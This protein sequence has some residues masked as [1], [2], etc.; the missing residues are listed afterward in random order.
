[1]PELV[2]ED[3]AADDGLGAANFGATVHRNEAAQMSQRRQMNAVHVPEHRV[4][5]G[6][7][8]LQ[9]GIARALA[10]AVH[11]DARRRRARL[12][13]GDGVRGGEAQI[14]V[15][16]KFDGQVGHAAHGGHGLP[17]RTGSMMPSVSAKR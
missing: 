6:C 7:D 15:A 9:R 3:I 10:K 17:D 2:G 1:M 13:G 5:R 4:Q 8:L 16:V 12:D 11:R 14:V